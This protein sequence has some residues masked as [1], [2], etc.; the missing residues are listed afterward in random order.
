MGHAQRQSHDGSLIVGP[1]LIEEARQHQRRRRKLVGTVLIAPLAVGC[2][3]VGGLFVAAGRQGTFVA[4]S[5]TSRSKGHTSPASR[6]SPAPPKKSL[7]P[8][9]PSNVVVL[10]PATGDVIATS[11]SERAGAAL[12]AAQNA[13][14]RASCEHPKHLAARSGTGTA[15][16]A[17]CRSGSPG[18]GRRSGSGSV[19]PS[20]TEV[21]GSDRWLV[22]TA[23]AIASG[24]GIEA[25]DWTT[26][27]D[28]IENLVGRL[29]MPATPT[30][31]IGVD[32]TYIPPGGSSVL[33]SACRPP[34]RSATRQ[35]VQY[36]PDR[37]LTISEFR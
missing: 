15:S 16:Y 26:E 31:E 9:S 3:I 28:G 11:P 13:A 24:I 22:S 19:H 25:I 32:C 21:R 2:L 14:G 5:A 18:C 27:G 34:F 23:L 10:N 33:L 20:L 4:H 36:I 12:Q 6:Q 29:A 7:S 30:F 35:N 1:Q 17:G 8:L 37:L